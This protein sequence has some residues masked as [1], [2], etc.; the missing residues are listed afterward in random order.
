M[1]NKTNTV[2]KGDKFENRAF[3]KL[4]NMLELGALPLN[5]GSSFIYQKKKYTDINGN[6]V[7]FD[8]A[9]ETFRGNATTP[10]IIT[11]IECKDHES[12]IQVEKIRAFADKIKD[13]GGHKGIFIAT[14]KFQEGAFNKARSVGIGLAIMDESNEVSWKLERIGK[15]GYQIKAEIKEYFIDN[16]DDT[17]KYPFVAI[18][19]YRYYTSIYDLLSDIVGHELKLPF[20]IPYI[21]KEEIEEKII[22][23]FN[24]NNREDIQY[25]ASSNELIDT[26][27][28]QF[29]VDFI[30]DQD[31]HDEIGYCN[32]KDNSIAISN[33]LEFESPRWR[34]TLA[35]EI[36]HYVLHKNL[37]KNYGIVVTNDDESNF[38]NTLNG[39]SN[40]LTKKV[41]IQANLFASFLLLPRVAFWKKY[42]VLFYELFQWRK[43]PYLYVDKQHDNIKNYNYIAQQISESF[44][45]SKEVIKFR[46][47]NDNILTWNL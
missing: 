13:V 1:A 8:I 31:L 14:S 27:K 4:K 35:H 15:Q 25:F 22:S 23:I 26:L 41:E 10:S 44:G 33:E 38:S 34:F 46:L 43:Y 11:L 47:I 24:L 5:P 39:L 29:E 6:D 3:S 45:V 18:D 2:A 40:K 42:T 19:R 21:S 7:E 30:F 12:P 16:D 28:Q 36:G 9:I 17:Y 20:D 32:F 37:F